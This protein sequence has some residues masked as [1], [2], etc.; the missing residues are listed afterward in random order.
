MGGTKS[1]KSSILGGQQTCEPVKLQLLCGNGVRAVWKSEDPLCEHAIIVFIALI[2]GYS[3]TD[4]FLIYWEEC[5]HEIFD[6]LN[7]I[8]DI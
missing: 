8:T 7:L 6:I 4:S 2:L 5:N 1:S 3:N